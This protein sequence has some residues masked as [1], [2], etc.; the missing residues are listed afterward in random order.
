[1]KEQTN[2]LSEETSPYL[3]Q[4]A[5]NPVHWQPWDEAA[6]STARELDR[7]I[8]LS[9]GYSTCHWCH[10]MEEESFQDAGVA[11]LMNA[12]FVCIKVDREE[13]PDVDNVY[14]RYAV[15]MTGSG[16]WPLNV[17]ITPEGKPFFAATYIPR[18]SSYGR[19]G[20]LELVPAISKS[21]K[22]RRDQLLNAAGKIS[23][24]L[25]G[26]GERPSVKEDGKDP[27]SLC[28]TRLSDSFDPVWGGFGGAPKF[29]APHNILF[30]LRYWKAGGDRRALEMATRTMAGIRYGGIW[31]QLGGG[32]HRYSTDREWHVPHFEKMLYDQALLAMAGLEAFQAT[33]LEFHARVAGETLDFAVREM[34]SPGGAFYSAWDADSP[35]GEGAFY[36]WSLEELR[37]LL[38]TERTEELAEIWDL[39]DR[40]DLGGMAGSATGLNVPRLELPPPGEALPSAPPSPDGDILELLLEC[41]GKRPKPFLD[42]KIL[43][44]WNGMMTAAAARGS[45]VLGRPDLLKAAEDAFSFVRGN[46]FAGK[47]EMVHSW[48]SGSAGERGFLDDHAFMIWACLELYCATLENGYLD[49][50][51][52]LQSAQD[53]LFLDPG[54]GEYRFSSG[55]DDAISLPA[56]VESRDGAVPSGTSIALMNLYRLWGIT[57]ETSLRR[58]A[59]SLA[60]ALAGSVYA[61]PSAHTMLAAGM[62]SGPSH[63]HV[64]LSGDPSTV[65]FREL[66]KAAR[67]AYNPDMT[68]SAESAEEEVKAV[69]CADGSCGPPVTT[70]SDLM[71]NLGGYP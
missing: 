38:G 22:N 8:F 48:I 68:I 64:T 63:P 25:F 36:A 53:R 69:I 46:M 24:T 43:A 35:G 2:R 11:R 62:L 44:D 42:T 47:G 54:T 65:E 55:G 58:R 30:L 5:D 32:I 20:M 3:L 61:S 41:R 18:E 51:L 67:A 16:G 28:F 49:F 39:D 70:P 23:A 52:D 34:R 14:M 45:W 50:A 9:I 21:W 37:E 27:A 40:G 31:D 71:K 6:F 57:G 7:P 13:R 15:A 56:T 59:D 17:V 19:R 4:H 1:M 12:A 10:V 60:G 33:G 66:L 29:P 26:S